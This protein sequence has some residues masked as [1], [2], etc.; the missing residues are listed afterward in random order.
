MNY[1]ICNLKM[2]ST[3]MFGSSCICFGDHHVCQASTNRYDQIYE[4]SIDNELYHMTLKNGITRI[5]NLQLETIF[6]V[7]YTIPFDKA[8]EVFNRAI[9]IG[10]FT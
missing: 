3:A 1:P 4:Y 9:S 6:K 10:A 8:I 2:M 7:N 5:V